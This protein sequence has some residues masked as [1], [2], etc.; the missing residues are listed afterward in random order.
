MSQVREVARA[1]RRAAADPAAHRALAAHRLVGVEE[2]AALGGR[3]LALGVDDLRHDRPRDDAGAVTL[4][5]IEGRHHQARQRVLG[6]AE[7]PQHLRVLLAVLRHRALRV[8]VVAAE[9]EDHEVGVAAADLAVQVFL[10][11][12]E[13]A[14]RQRA[15]LAHLVPHHAGHVALH[16]HT[17]GPR[18]ATTGRA[19]RQRVLT[20]VR[21]D[22]LPAILQLLRRGLEHHGLLVV[23]G[24]ADVAALRCA[25]VPQLEARDLAP[26][27]ALRRR[28]ERDLRAAD[29][30]EGG[31]AEPVVAVLLAAAEDD[32]AV[33]PGRLLLEARALMLVA[34]VR[35]PEQVKTVA[36]VAEAGLHLQA[37]R[38]RDA[39]VADRRVAVVHH[40]RGRTG[41]AELARR[42]RGIKR[43]EGL[44]VLERTLHAL[45]VLGARRQRGQLLDLV[46]CHDR[47]ADLAVDERHRPV[48]GLELGAGQRLR[49]GQLGVHFGDGLPL[50]EQHAADE[51]PKRHVVHLGRPRPGPVPARHRVGQPDQRDQRD[52]RRDDLAEGAA[53]VRPAGVARTAELDAKAVVLPV[54]ESCVRV[55]GRSGHGDF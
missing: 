45:A 26:H 54:E 53:R 4:A 2:G 3:D 40:P 16:H 35:L 47:L 21:L 5:V 49:R 44:D 27:R 22:H 25:R 46:A 38:A 50:A 8:H 33:V 23:E 31:A 13:H 39:V 32:K 18:L 48:L 43:V 51:V 10:V 20:V 14:P 15:D 37:D 7:Q 42:Q 41:V 19:D 36:S 30:L 28:A 55:V 9:H 17:V 52:H 1:E 12:V 11:E 6:A 34:G 29:R 24:H